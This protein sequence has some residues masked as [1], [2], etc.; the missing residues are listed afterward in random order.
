MPPELMS[1]EDDHPL[2]TL[3]VAGFFLAAALL[4][5]AI[6]DSARRGCRTIGN[7]L[8]QARFEGHAPR[9]DVSPKPPLRDPWDD[10]PWAPW[11]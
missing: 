4:F 9:T 10:A 8:A 5:P 11:S 7:L 3:V 1:I 6:I 2:L